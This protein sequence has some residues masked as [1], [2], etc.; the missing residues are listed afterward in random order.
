MGYCI[1]RANKC[2][3]VTTLTRPNRPNFRNI[4]FRP[5]TPFSVA[6]DVFNRYSSECRETMLIVADDVTPF[7]YIMITFSWHTDFSLVVNV[8]APVL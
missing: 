5:K 1:P 7:L 6:T 8:V 3:Y 2:C 4:G